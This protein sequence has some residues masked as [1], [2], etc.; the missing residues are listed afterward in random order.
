MRYLLVLI[1]AAVAMAAD[2]VPFVVTFTSSAPGGNPPTCSGEYS[3]PVSL[4]GTGHATHVGLFT[5]T[6]SHCVNPSTLDFALGQNTMTAANGD[7]L[8]GT[9]SGHM[10]ITGPNTAAIYGVFVTTGGT[11]RFAGAT[12][13]GVAT[14]TLDLITGEASDLVLRGTISRPKK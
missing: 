6:Q 4:V 2:Q 13:G 5:N 8:V 11:G 10:E 12:G 9:Y 7:T 1:L 14:G 3:V